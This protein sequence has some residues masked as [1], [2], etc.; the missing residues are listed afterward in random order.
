[1]MMCTSPACLRSVQAD[2]LCQ[3][4]VAD[5]KHVIHQALGLK[6]ATNAGYLIPRSAIVSVVLCD[7]AYIASLNSKHRG[8]SEPTDVLSFEVGDSE[9]D[10][11]VSEWNTWR[12]GRDAYIGHTLPCACC[13]RVCQ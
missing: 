3:K 7:D 9:L 2:Q 6:A 11:K 1:M 4:V 10:Y 5:A 8:K 13:R 12:P